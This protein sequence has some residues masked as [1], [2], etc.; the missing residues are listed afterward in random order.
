MCGHRPVLAQQAETI[1]LALSG[2]KPL[3]IV[4]QHALELEP[5][6]QVALDGGEG[7]LFLLPAQSP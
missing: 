5:K 2:D 7:R 3:L 6:L 1:Q 4:G